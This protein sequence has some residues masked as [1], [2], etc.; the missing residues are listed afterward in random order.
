MIE[1]SSTCILVIK[2]SFLQDG[3]RKG[4]GRV[5]VIDATGELVLMDDYI[6]T[7][8]GD[9]IHDYLTQYR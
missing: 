4:V 5:S 3:S 2:S 9:V 7:C 6:V 8:E 1:Q